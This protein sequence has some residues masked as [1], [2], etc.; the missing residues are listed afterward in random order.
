VKLAVISDLLE[1]RWFSMDLVAEHAPER[2]GLEVGR[3]R[4]AL[5][6]GLRQLVLAPGQGAVARRARKA[7]LAWGRYV[8]YPVHVLARRGEFDRYHV[9]DHSYAHLLFELPSER[10]GV[11]CHDIDAFRPLFQGATSSPHQRALARLALLGMQRA[12]VVFHSS[13]AV[14]DEI[15]A[16]GLVPAARLRHVPYG[17]AKEFHADGSA[18]GPLV[19][20]SEPFVLHVG[21]LIPR[22]NPDFVAALAVRL[23]QA[24]PDLRFVQVGGRFTDEQRRLFQVGGVSDRVVQ[25]ESMTRTELAPVYRRAAAV[26]L[27]SLAEGFGLPV[28]E[29]LACGAPVVV[30]DIAVLTQ[31]GGEA[32]VARPNDDLDAF[33]RAVLDALLGQAPTR[34]TRLAVASRYGWQAH[35]AAIVD[36]YLAL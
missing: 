15:L 16:H 6:W 27:P 9:A 12:S 32:V 26:V 25:F 2:Q 10:S 13:L 34:A 4:P 17:V 11:Y 5:P 3:I 1:E 28:V 7:A 29:A 35:A 23:C 14:R 22:K 24:R 36:A 33:Q 21:S 19:N 30:S 20:V 31:I 18:D 8:Q